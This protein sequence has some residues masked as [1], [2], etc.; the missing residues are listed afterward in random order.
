MSL[1]RTVLPTLA[2]GPLARFLVLLKEA[3]LG[4][5]GGRKDARRAWPLFTNRE[6]LLPAAPENGAAP[7]GS[8]SLA[9]AGR[10]PRRRLLA[11]L[12][13]PRATPGP[14]ANSL[15]IQRPGSSAERLVDAGPSVDLGEQS[16]VFLR[17]MLQ[18][19]APHATRPSLQVPPAHS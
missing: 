19:L 14:P 17:R 6:W 8:G 1:G 4:A 5:R 16:P 12:Q 10:G 18:P 2:P 15:R 11:S 13:G 7:A 3:E 9:P